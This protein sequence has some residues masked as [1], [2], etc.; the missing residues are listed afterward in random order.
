MDQALKGRRILVVEDEALVIMLLEAMLE[1]LGCV[2]VAAADRVEDALALIEGG[3]DI[4][5]ALLDINVAGVQSFPVAA[6][7][8]ARGVPFIFCSGYGAG[9]LP[10][11][12]AGR[13]VV[14][15]PYAEQALRR[16]LMQ[17]LDISEA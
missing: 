3:A 16:A 14:Q 9:G 10:P 12:W 11:E 8:A 15:K 7:L 2:T 4:D 5:A 13:P 1:E 17:V 6:A